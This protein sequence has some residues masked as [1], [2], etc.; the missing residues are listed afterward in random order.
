[1]TDESDLGGS[2]YYRLVLMLIPEGA[3]AKLSHQ[4]GF[5]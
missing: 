4:S 3:G 2:S 5:Y 1:M